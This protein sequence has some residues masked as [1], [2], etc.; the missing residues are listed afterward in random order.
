[1]IGKSNRERV[2]VT[3]YGAV[4]PLGNAEDTWQA[5][6]L[7]RSGIRRITGTELRHSPVKIGGEV[8][9]LFPEKYLSRKEIRR[10]PRVSQFA[11]IAASR[12]CLHAKL[13]KDEFDL[14]G[15]RAATVIGTTMG[16]HLLAEEMTSAYRQNGHRRPNPVEFVNCLPNMPAHYVSQFMGIRGA[17]HTPVA[18]CATGTQAIGLAFDLIQTGAA[19]VVV[20]GATEA[21]LRDYIIA[22][23]ASMQALATGY[24]DCPEQASRPFD[25][26]R[27]GFVLS[28]GSGVLV[29]ERIEH[30][31]ARNAEIYGEVAGHSNTSD[32]Y[33]VAIIDP[34]VVG[35]VNAMDGALQHAGLAPDDIDYVNAHGTG[36]PANDVLETRSIQ[37]VFGSHARTLSIS[38]NKSMLGHMMASAGAVEAIMSLL[39]IRDSI[40]PPT[41]NL[42]SPDPDCDLDYTPNAAKQADVRCVMSNNFGLGGQNASIIL[43]QYL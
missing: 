16:P 26:E 30:A 9:D 35:M 31:K 38:S 36:T 4:T 17:L 25:I 15:T 33:H 7:G 22:G 19:D 12:A 18:A 42:E 5:L 34:D 14:M 43:K 40:V 20:A 29:L 8:R 6:L 41:I 37:E 32:A 10:M 13:S 3:G 1:M 24:E 11:V 39:T 2:V 21:I 28:E 27:S 23:F